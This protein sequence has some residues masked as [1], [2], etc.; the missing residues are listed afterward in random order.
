MGCHSCDSPAKSEDSQRCRGCKGENEFFLT[1]QFS[2]GKI[3]FEKSV[4]ISWENGKF[5]PLLDSLSLSR[6]GKSQV[7]SVQ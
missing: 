2:P 7:N 6:H 4:A 5:A 3:F 1:A